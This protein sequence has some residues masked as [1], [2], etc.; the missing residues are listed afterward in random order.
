MPVGEDIN[1][2]SYKDNDEIRNN[3]KYHKNKIPY[4]GAYH[5]NYYPK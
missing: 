4:K 1:D 2:T 3:E 5:S